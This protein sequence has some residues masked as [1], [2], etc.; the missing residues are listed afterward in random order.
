MAS[1]VDDSD[2]MPSDVGDSDEMPSEVGDSDDGEQIEEHDLADLS[3]YFGSSGEC[4]P[5]PLH[6]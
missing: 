1:D 6:E 2:E 5:T 4:S 3:S